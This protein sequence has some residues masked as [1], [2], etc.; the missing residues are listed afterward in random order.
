[1]VKESMT[2]GSVV[3]ARKTRPLAPYFEATGNDE[4]V[5]RV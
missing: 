3:K 4:G 5:G 2:E 1:M